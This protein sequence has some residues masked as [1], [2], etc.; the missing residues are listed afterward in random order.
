MPIFGQ[1]L[2][3]L[4]KAEFVKNIDTTNNTVNN[5]QVLAVFIN[6]RVV[7]NEKFLLSF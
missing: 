2:F 6:D 4:I 3:L 5:T 7:F 1:T